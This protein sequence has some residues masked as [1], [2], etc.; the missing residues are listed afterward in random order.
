[1]ATTA[2]VRFDRTAR[3]SRYLSKTMPYHNQR[4][5]FPFFLKKN[6]G[7]LIPL[8]IAKIR[9]RHNMINMEYEK[10][11]EF[12]NLLKAFNKAKLG[13]RNKESVAKFE[14]NLMES[15]LYLQHLL[16]TG[17]YKMSGYY[18]FYV[19]EPKQRLVKSCHFKDKVVQQA[20]CE[21]IVK[22]KIS[23]ILIK[24]NYA[25]QPGK[26]THFGLDRLSGF[27]RSYY[28]S[29]KNKLILK[30]KEGGKYPSKE[31]LK[32]CTEGYVLKCDIRKFFYNIRH[33]VIKSMIARNFEDER[34][35]KLIY[36][37]ID[38]CPDPGIPIGNQLSQWLAVL[39][40]N[41]MDH[42]I[43]SKLGIK[44]YGRYM[45]DFYLIHQDKS[46]LK[47]CL[48][49]IKNYL[50]GVGLELNQKTQIFPLRHGIDFLGFHTYLTDSGKVIRK[51]RRNSKN[52]MKKKIRKYK[53]M[54][55]KGLITEKEIKLSLKAWKAHASHGNC[56]NLIKNMEEYYKEVFKKGENKCLKD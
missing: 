17:K 36:H 40:L 7:I 33:D 25:S 28:F 3:L 48:K 34:V 27:M 9:V 12:E 10:I 26:G 14:N 20:L 4:K 35:R 37:I 13:N 55:D 23:K 51:L 54:L 30:F 39:Y 15:I 43:K 21:E 53:K 41:D 11:T 32:W 19:Y 47:Y 16:K 50:K 8:S 46:Y 52:K 24:D 49:V 22:P 56:Y 5:L 31:A 42:M 18:E 29:R 1:M 6:T 38:S 2:S 44:Y 45:D